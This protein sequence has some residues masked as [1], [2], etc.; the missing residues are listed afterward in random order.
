MCW[1]A[2]DRGIRLAEKRSF[3]SDIP[4]W[5]KI[6]DEIYIDIMKNGWSEDREAFVQF[7]GKQLPSLSNCCNRTVAGFIVF[8]LFIAGSDTLDASVLIMPLVFFMAPN[9][10]RFIKTLDAILMNVADGGIL[11]VQI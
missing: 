2:L 8:H 4:K 7:Y 10:P 1:V 9:D 3:P 5:R 6:R 11:N